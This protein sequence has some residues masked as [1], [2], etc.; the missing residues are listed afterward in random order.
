M[1]FFLK[2]FQNFTT[3]SLML[4]SSYAFTVPSWYN[5]VSPC[6]SYLSVSGRYLAPRKQLRAES[7]ILECSVISK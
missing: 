1:S 5:L 4:P 6:W 2:Y 7:I 3:P